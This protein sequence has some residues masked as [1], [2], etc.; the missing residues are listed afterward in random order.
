MITKQNAD[1]KQKVI[2]GLFF[3]QRIYFEY[4]CNFSKI[5]YTFSFINGV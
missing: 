5:H 2:Y 3:F 1:M 4:Y